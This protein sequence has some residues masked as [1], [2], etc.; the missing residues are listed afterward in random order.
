MTDGQGVKIIYD[1]VG[2]TTFEKGLRVLGRR[3]CMALYGQAGGPGGPCRLGH[4]AQRFA[5]S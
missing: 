4:A 2:A 1:A 5:C 3:G